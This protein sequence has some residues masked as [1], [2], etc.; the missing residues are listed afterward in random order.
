MDT[1]VP[2]PGPGQGAAPDGQAALG[3]AC[4][5]GTVWHLQQHGPGPKAQGNDPVDR[6]VA[7]KAAHHK[8]RLAL[9]RLQRRRDARVDFL[10]I[11]VEIGSEEVVLRH[12]LVELIIACIACHKNPSRLSRREGFCGT[13]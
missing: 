13:L 1:A 12:P 6:D 9:R 10:K 5:P 3:D 4:V 8:L 11:L 7:N 2:P